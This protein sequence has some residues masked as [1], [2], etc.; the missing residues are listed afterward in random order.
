[1]FIIAHIAAG[2]LIGKI[3]NNYS[4]ALAGALLIDIDHLIP[5]AKHKI[6][7]NPKKFWKTVT[8]SSD[9]LGNQRNYLHSFFA[10]IIISII[11][12]QI[13]FHNGCVLSLGYLSHLLLDFFD[14][15]DFYL[16]YPF[17]Y[18]F[19]GPIKY[20]SKHEFMFT[21]AL[22]AAFLVLIFI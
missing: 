21:T 13:D 9:T 7:F 8:D 10:W 17:K 22:I 4:L 18:N 15:S 20:L 16:F 3:T 11:A 5:Y 19:I 2:L 6:I 12:L 1:M 14:K